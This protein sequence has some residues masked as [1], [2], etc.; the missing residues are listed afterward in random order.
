MRGERVSMLCRSVILFGVTFAGVLG[1][2]SS[3]AAQAITDLQTPDTPLVLKAQG[4]FYV[5]GGKSEQSK[6]E[7]GDAPPCRAQYRPSLRRAEYRLSI[8]GPNRPAPST[9]SPPCPCPRPVHL[10]E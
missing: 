9:V 8:S 5:G 10:K 4:S 6:V 1:M 3:G 2:A 7:L